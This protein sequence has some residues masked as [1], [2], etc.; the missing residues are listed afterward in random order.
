MSAQIADSNVARSAAERASDVVN[1]K[2]FGAKGDGITDDA[3]AINS[4]V[5]F[6][7]G[8]RRIDGEI[9]GRLVF[10][11]GRY[12]VKSS[13]DLTRIRSRYVEIE[14]SGAVLLGKT[15]GKPV[16]D[17]LGT[18]Y[19]RIRDLS[20]EGDPNR[21]PSIG[22]QIGRTDTTI[23][24]SSDNITLD[25]VFVSGSFSFTALY[26]LNAETSMFDRINLWNSYAG[27]NSY[28]LVQDGI[29]HW[30]AHSDF[31]S[32]NAPPDA[33]Q[34][35]NENLFIN[36]DIRH[37]GGGTP[38]WM[39]QT[40]R[41]E[42]INSY[43]ANTKGS[44]AVALYSAANTD[45]NLMLKLDAHVETSSVTDAILLTGPNATP[46]LSGLQ[47]R[48]HFS[49]VRMSLLK[50]DTG[51][52]SVR[53]PG[54][55]FEIGGF[56]S[57]SARVFLQPAIWSGSADVTLQSRIFWNG[58]SALSAIITSGSTKSLILNG[59]VSATTMHLT[60]GVPPNSSAAC[61]TGQISAD[62]RYFYVCTRTNEWKRVELN[63]W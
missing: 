61:A 14:G 20:I 55:R 56:A 31:V 26:N 60:G 27:P 2:D 29:N 51:I 17:A 5:A 8:A 33:P 48:D 4:A 59:D 43:V 38:I 57:P 10:P 37:F 49:F 12:V 13:I 46:T 63:N 9:A 23:R 41:H 19:L 39:A 50:A 34:S 15:I 16:V 25:A 3:P 36:A 54:A 24:D 11:Q 22:I 62:Y 1:V 42:F 53:L 40:S 7:R 21:V 52:T 44:N 35:F 28:A 32:E 6:L 47:V 45:Q 30:R 18:R 58:T